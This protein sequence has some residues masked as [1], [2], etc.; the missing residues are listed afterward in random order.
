M[1]INA[2]G[3]PA[4]RVDGVGRKRAP[5]LRY[6]QIVGG[7]PMSYIVVIALLLF[8]LA[9]VGLVDFLVAHVKG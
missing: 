3:H 8:C 1:I 6:T 7:G 4:R 5:Q 2:A 9:L